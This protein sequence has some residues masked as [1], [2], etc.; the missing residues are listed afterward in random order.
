MSCPIYSKE[1]EIVLEYCAGLLNGERAHGFEQH[2]AKCGEC[3]RM[4]A[5]QRQVWEALDR[6]ATPAIS[7]DFD[8]RLY[9]RIAQEQPGWRQWLTRF[10]RPSAPMAIWKPAMS[11]VAVCAVLAIGLEMREPHAPVEPA[12][13]QA[14]QPVAHSV[15][16]LAPSAPVDIEQ[17]ANAL[18][19]LDQLAPSPALKSKSPR[20]M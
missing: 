14:V 8:A 5:E 19:E 4:V 1:R 2:L 7:E 20:V 17:V 10:L 6:W 9:A 16:N 11:V 3:A 13:Q 12:P 18:D 15:S